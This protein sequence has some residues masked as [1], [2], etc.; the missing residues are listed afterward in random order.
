MSF[1]L[2]FLTS[3]MAFAI[4]D[5]G[6]DNPADAITAFLQPLSQGE[7][8]IATSMSALPGQKQTKNALI[9][10]AKQ[11]YGE[12]PLSSTL[13]TMIQQNGKIIAYRQTAQ[14]T[15]RIGGKVMT[16]F[17]EL[18]F[19]FANAKKNCMIKVV[20]PTL[21]GGFH[22]MDV[23]FDGNGN[24]ITTVAPGASTGQ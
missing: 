12:R 23:Q 6:F 15:S 22:I 14:P 3:S 4:S 17:Y 2:L 9:Q 7:K 20:Q 24:G 11:N 13:R 19:Q 5:E 21:S 16:Y 1:L 10:N 18:T 8:G